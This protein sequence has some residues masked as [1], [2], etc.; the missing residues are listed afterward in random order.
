METD[1]DGDAFEA[2]MVK[3]DGTQVTLKMDE[4]FKVTSTDGR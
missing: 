2:H 4:S 1:A 3:S